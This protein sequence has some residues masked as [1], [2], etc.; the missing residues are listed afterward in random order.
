MSIIP[1]VIYRCNSIIKILVVLRKKKNLYNSYGTLKLPKYFLKNP[2][3]KRNWEALDFQTLFLL[4]LGDHT[5]L[6]SGL[7]H[8]LVLGESLQV[9][10]RN[11]MTGL[12]LHARQE[13]YLL[14]YLSSTQSYKIC[15]YWNKDRFL[16]QW[17]RIEIPMISTLMYGQFKVNQGELQ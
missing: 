6:C 13:L 16:D 17:N 3:T 15:K 2:E 12:N 10:S 7:A 5:H 9:G 4:Y 14:C 1:K 11:R 8:D